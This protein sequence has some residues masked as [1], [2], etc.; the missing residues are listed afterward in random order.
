MRKL[1]VT[2][3]SD[4]SDLKYLYEIDCNVCWPLGTDNKVTVSYYLYYL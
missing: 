3:F 1:T 4:L 2:S